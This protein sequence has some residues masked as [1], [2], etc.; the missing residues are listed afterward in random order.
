L[1]IN[2]SVAPIKAARRACGGSG[3]AR[4]LDMALAEGIMAVLY[5][6]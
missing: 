2:G 5:H 3:R 1:R 6:R 4:R